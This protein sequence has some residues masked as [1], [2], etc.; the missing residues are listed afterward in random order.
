MNIML[1][2]K[3][4]SLQSTS[5]KEIFMNVSSS[6]TD[7]TSHNYGNDLNST[8]QHSKSQLDKRVDNITVDSDNYITEAN[9]KT[10]MHELSE[11]INYFNIKNIN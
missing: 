11:N 8:N 9:I 2:M 4:H 6:V 3:Q 1:N 10:Y 7:S 5:S